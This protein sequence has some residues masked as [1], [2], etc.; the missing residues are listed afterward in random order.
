MGKNRSP[1]LNF[2]ILSEQRGKDE[3]NAGR[4]KL[5]MAKRRKLHMYEWEMGQV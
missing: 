4:E 5:D 3:G 2:H 1:G